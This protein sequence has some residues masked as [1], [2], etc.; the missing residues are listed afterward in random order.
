MPLRTGTNSTDRKLIADYMD[1]GETSAKRIADRLMLP[2]DAVKNAMKAINE[3]LDSGV[4]DKVLV[5]DKD[6]KPVNDEL[7][8]VEAAEAELAGDGASAEPGAPKPA[9]PAAKDAK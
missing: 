5:L 8:G 6:G 9:K 3:K 1:E 7:T 4:E 2:V